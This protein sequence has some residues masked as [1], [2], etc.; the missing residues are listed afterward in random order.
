MQNYKKSLLV[1]DVNVSLVF[2]LEYNVLLQVVLKH[3]TKATRQTLIARVE[4]C[5]TQGGTH[6]RRFNNYYDK[7]LRSVSDEISVNTGSSKM[8]E[9]RAIWNKYRHINAWFDTLK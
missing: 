4:A 1:L 2:H 6:F 9:S 8:E 7:V 3:K 5:L